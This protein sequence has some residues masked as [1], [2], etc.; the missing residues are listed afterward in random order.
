MLSWHDFKVCISFKKQT[1]HA[2]VC[3]YLMAVRDV[4][5]CMVRQCALGFFF[6]ENIF[7]CLTL[8]PATC[9]ALIQSSLVKFFF[10]WRV[11]I[12]YESTDISFLSLLVAWISLCS[13]NKA[14]FI[15]AKYQM[16]AF[17]HR[18]PCRED[19]SV[20]AKDLSKVSG[21]WDSTGKYHW[22]PLVA[23]GFSGFLHYHINQ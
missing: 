21:F 13:P 23:S 16:L 11:Y 1:P 5:L 7:P 3:R 9:K 8:P 2:A 15:R 20:T 6:N 12:T 4:F 10:F 18:L 17:V 22:L 14:E 19:D